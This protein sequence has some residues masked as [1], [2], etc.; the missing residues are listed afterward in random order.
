MGGELEQE[1]GSRVDRRWDIPLLRATLRLGP[2]A[3]L[4]LLLALLLRLLI[5]HLFCLRAGLALN[6]L[7]GNGSARPKGR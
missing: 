7:A 5:L 4:D 1:I 2:L 6:L 3:L